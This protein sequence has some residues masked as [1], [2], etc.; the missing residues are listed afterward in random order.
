ML[1]VVIVISL[2]AAA[3][4]VKH[5]AVR[6]PPRVGLWE[7]QGDAGWCGRRPRNSRQEVVRTFFRLCMCGK[8]SL[9]ACGCVTSCV[10]EVGGVPVPRQRQ[11]DSAAYLV[12]GKCAVGNDDERERQGGR[13]EPHLLA[14]CD[15]KRALRQGRE[16]EEAGDEYARKISSGLP[17]PDI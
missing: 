9:C 3:L 5:G 1:G 14:L 6:G 11:A 10:P 15:W 7:Q 13:L 8:R 4:Q 17:C 2:A 16:A 12:Q